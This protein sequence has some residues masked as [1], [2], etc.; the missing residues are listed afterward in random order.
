MR[1]HS[2]SIAAFRRATRGGNIFRQKEIL[3]YW[4]NYLSCLK[5]WPSGNGNYSI[6]REIQRVEDY[7]IN[8][9]AIKTPL[10]CKAAK[11]RAYRRKIKRLRETVPEG[12]S[13]QEL[14]NRNE[15]NLKI[16]TLKSRIQGLEHVDRCG[17]VNHKVIYGAV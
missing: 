17:M 13:E 15:I 8:L 11:V 1:A 12:I 3:E 7:I 6:S 14:S 2:F 9:E 10:V 4:H 16:R 5:V